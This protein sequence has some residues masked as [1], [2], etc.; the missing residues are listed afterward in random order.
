MFKQK[1]KKFQSMLP[2]G[3][4]SNNSDSCFRKPIHYTAKSCVSDVNAGNR[5]SSI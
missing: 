2:V 3:S 1:S 5:Y 4:I